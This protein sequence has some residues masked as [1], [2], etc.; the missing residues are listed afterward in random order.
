MTQLYRVNSKGGP[1]A[2][3]GAGS[4]DD[5][6]GPKLTGGSPYRPATIFPLHQE[7]LA[8]AG[9]VGGGR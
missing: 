5:D 2:R 3:P 4:V 8:D 6:G 9:S 7:R 1:R